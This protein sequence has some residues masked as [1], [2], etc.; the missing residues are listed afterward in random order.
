MANIYDRNPI[1]LDT[2]TSA[3]DLK[4][5]MGYPTG[6]QFKIKSIE[7]V[8]PTTIG[9]TADIYTDTG[10]TQPLFNQTCVTANQNINKPFGNEGEWFDNICIGVSGVTHGS[11]KIF[12]A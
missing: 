12:L 2:F 1:H 11:I 3:I 6:G 4:T 9:D 7:W 10:L 8:R 5:T